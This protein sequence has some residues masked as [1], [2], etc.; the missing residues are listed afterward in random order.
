MELAA[1]LCHR[2][3][4]LGMSLFSSHLLVYPSASEGKKASSLVGLLP[5]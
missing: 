2:A 3:Q 1:L 5:F 4:A